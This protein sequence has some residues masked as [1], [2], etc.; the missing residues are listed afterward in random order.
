M[1]IFRP[2]RHI[3]LASILTTAFIGTAHAQQARPLPLSDLQRFTT[4]VEHIKNYYVSP[5]Q[6]EQLFEDAIKGMLAG[7]DP[8]SAY[9]PPEEFS[10]LK[11]STSGRFGGLGIEV[12]MEEGL[13]KVISPIDGTPAAKAGVLPED[14]I[15]KLDDTSVKGLSLRD[16]VQ[17]MRGER[18]TDIRLT[19]LRKG[20]AEPVILTVTRDIIRVQSVKSEVLDKHYGYIRISQFQTRT[21]DDLIKSINALKKETNG[22]MKGM[23]L[24]LRNNPGGILE[25]SVKVSDAFLDAKDLEHDK[26]IVY[27]EGR[28]PGSKIREIA[29]SSDLINGIPMVV[30]VN[31]GSASASEI[32]AGALQDHKRALVVGDATFGKGSVQTVLPLKD[33]HGLKLTTALY[34]TPKGRSIQATGIAPDIEIKNMSVKEQQNQAVQLKEKDLQGHIENGN[35]PSAQ[36]NDDDESLAARDYQLNEA[37]NLLKGLVLL[38]R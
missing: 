11:V 9:L 33:N 25:A 12:T 29:R 4:V 30:L 8:H 7:L 28:L 1:E 3:V 15:I 14:M 23:I 13:V 38:N 36:T 31:G 10:D 19:I 32:V 20:Q 21:S 17:I 2:A 6:D 34:Y 27:T 37:L 16:A 5:A 18:G 24:D 26:L 35:K 22:D